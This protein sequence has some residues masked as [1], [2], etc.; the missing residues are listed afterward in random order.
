MKKVLY[1]ALVAGGLLL[2][3]LLMLSSC[4]TQQPHDIPDGVYDVVLWEG[5]DPVEIEFKNGK[6]VSEDGSPYLID[7]NLECRYLYVSKDL[8]GSPHVRCV[9]DYVWRVL[10][11]NSNKRVKPG[12]TKL[13]A[14]WG[15]A[16]YICVYMIDDKRIRKEDYVNYYEGLSYDAPSK[17]GYVFDGWFNEDFTIR[18]S[19]GTKGLFEYRCLNDNMEI[20]GNKLTLYGR[21]L[22]KDVTLTLHYGDERTENRTVNRYSEIKSAELPTEKGNG[23]HLVGW[24]L[25]PNGAF[26][27]GKIEENMTL[28]AVWSNYKTVHFHNLTESAGMEC[29]EGNTLTPPTYERPGY[30]FDGWF[31]TEAT[32]GSA[33]SD[34]S[35]TSLQSDYYAKWTPVSYTATPHAPGFTLSPITYQYGY[36][37]DLP[38]I[39]KSGYIFEGWCLLEDCSDTPLQRLPETAYGNITLYAKFT[40]RSFTITLHATEGFA[41]TNLPVTFDASFTAPVP[42][43]SKTFL[44][45]F[46]LSGEQYTDEKGNSLGVYQ[47]HESINLYAKYAEDEQEGGQQA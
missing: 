9:T 14:A 22:P 8:D 17:D 21:Y 33:V 24:S 36:G 3:A 26:F 29:Y 5:E 45:W 10:P 4:A 35:Y 31:L 18:Y 1:T 16:E 13:Y 38:M 6:M 43:N 28:H 40:P 12:K 25:T 23:R 41:E 20:V 30:R 11:G 15:P 44:G 34:F 47:N 46:N 39:S 7:G 27:N 42:S 2:L 19:D 37:A 32:T